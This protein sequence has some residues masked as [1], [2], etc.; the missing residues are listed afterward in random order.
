MLRVLEKRNVSTDV[1]LIELPEHVTENGNSKTKKS[2]GYQG[3]AQGGLGG[4]EQK[5]VR[6]NK[7]F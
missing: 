7:N 4:L 5:F 2:V 6:K 1:F 3:C